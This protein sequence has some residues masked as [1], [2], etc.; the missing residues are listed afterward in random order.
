MNLGLHLLCG[1][2]LFYLGRATA[3]DLRR[4]DGGAPLDVWAPA[5]GALLFLVHPMATESVAYINSRSG[6][7][8]AALGL[9]ALLLFVR[10]QT[11][12][13][14]GRQ[15]CHVASLVLALLA[16]CSKESAAVLPLLMGLYL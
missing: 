4:G 14:R 5:L 12:R 2:L 8:A 6:L 3:R 1:L 9:G 7:L 11:P 15:A 13:G 16:M 10:S